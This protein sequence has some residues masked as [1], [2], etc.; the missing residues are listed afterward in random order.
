M[1]PHFLRRE[2]RTLPV[3]ATQRVL[4]TAGTIQQAVAVLDTA[5][6]LLAVDPA[7]RTTLDTVRERP[8][9]FILF[10]ARDEGRD[11]LFNVLPPSVGMRRRTGQPRA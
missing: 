10:W 2:A 9:W 11:Y 6:G 1:R 4:T 5:Q 3:R 8:D 7:T